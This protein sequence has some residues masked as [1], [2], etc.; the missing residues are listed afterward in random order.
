MKFKSIEGFSVF[1]SQEGKIVIEQKSL[2]FGK[3][4][5][6]FLTL[7]QFYGI[8][9]WVYSNKEQI[10]SAWNEGVENDSQA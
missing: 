9:H 5:Q 10:F 7:Q 8:E 3:P 2:E 6:V 1:I 4:V